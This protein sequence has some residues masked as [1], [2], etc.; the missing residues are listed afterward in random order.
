M[1]LALPAEALTASLPMPLANG[2]IAAVVAW[3]FVFQTPE[4]FEHYW[5]LLAV[6]ALH[7]AVTGVAD[8]ANAAFRVVQPR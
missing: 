6:V 5:T 7:V 8:A 1:R 3:D 4:F 2:E